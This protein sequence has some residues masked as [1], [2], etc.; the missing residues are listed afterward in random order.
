MVKVIFKIIGILIALDLLFFFGT[1]ATA[2]TD[3]KPPA[4]GRVVYWALKYILGFPM[5]LLNNRFPF[6]LESG[7]LPVVGII[8]IILNNIIL[9]FVIYGLGK[10]LS[11]IFKS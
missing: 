2:M 9:A 3:D 11:S 4:I 6:F 10:M 1:I 8:L 5:V 7:Q